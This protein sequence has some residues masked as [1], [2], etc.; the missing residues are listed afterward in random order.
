MNTKVKQDQNQI[1]NYKTKQE[2]YDHNLTMYSQFK[3]NAQI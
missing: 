3:L 2:N 1:S